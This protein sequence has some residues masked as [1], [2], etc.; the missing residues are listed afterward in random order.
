M[1]EH[2]GGG[3]CGWCVYPRLKMFRGGYDGGGQEIKREDGVSCCVWYMPLSLFLLVWL[4]IWI[5]N[6]YE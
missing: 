2:G 5:I 6:D 1:I 4:H 3:G